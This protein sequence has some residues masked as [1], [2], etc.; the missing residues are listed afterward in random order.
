M[1]RQKGRTLSGGKKAERGTILRASS[2]A[3]GTIVDIRMSETSELICSCVERSTE[4]A[5]A[6]RASE[7][8]CMFSVLVDRLRMSGTV[9]CSKAARTATPPVYMQVSE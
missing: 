4:T 2:R 1:Y 9:E 5:W 6:E 3:N 7:L 8:A